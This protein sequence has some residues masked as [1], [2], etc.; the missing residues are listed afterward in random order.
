MAVYGFG[1]YIG[2][3]HVVQWRS[4]SASGSRCHLQR[5]V[6]EPR[7]RLYRGRNYFAGF[8]VGGAWQG[9]RY[10]EVMALAPENGTN[11]QAWLING[12][13]PAGPFT[14]SARPTTNSMTKVRWR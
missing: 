4:A 8:S 5:Q 1:A 14:I 2:S 3:G 13:V 9:G 12:Y 11:A 10:N 6:Q 7:C